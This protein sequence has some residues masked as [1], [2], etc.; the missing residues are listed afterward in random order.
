[1]SRTRKKATKKAK[2]KGHKSRLEVRQDGYGP[3]LPNAGLHAI[4]PG[5]QN[6][7]K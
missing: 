6:R 2:G 7:K 3:D 1:V 4:K 5:S